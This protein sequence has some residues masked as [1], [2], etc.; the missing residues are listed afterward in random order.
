M[1]PFPTKR[2]Q[3]DEGTTH[4]ARSLATKMDPPREK[5]EDNTGPQEEETL[6]I[7][8]NMEEEEEEEEESLA[9]LVTSPVPSYCS[10]AFDAKTH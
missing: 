2:P 1:R 3:N 6:Y 4:E 7:R 8:N 9:N 10:R 5:L